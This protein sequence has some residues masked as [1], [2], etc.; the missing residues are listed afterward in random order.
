MSDDPTNDPKIIIHF[1]E[2]GSSTDWGNL[3][4]CYFEAQA[5]PDNYQFFGSG[6]D[7]IPTMPEFLAPDTPGF[8]FIRA[9]M[10]WTIFDFEIDQRTE[11]AKG[12]WRNPRRPARGDDD[13]HF[14]AAAGG[15][16]GVEQNASSAAA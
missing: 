2:G 12:N 10:L 15:G 4:D 8:Q 16:G 11:T 14:Q 9:G 1:V 3:M 7:H 5:S 13:G 6:G